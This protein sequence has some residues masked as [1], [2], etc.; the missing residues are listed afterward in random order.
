MMVMRHAWVVAVILA[1]ASVLSGQAPGVLRV[2]IVL[3]DA[4]QTPTPVPRHAL[5]ISDT[6]PTAAPR[7]ILTGAN[8]TA[9]VKLR[10]GSYTVESDRAVVFLGTAYQWTQMVEVVAGRD[11]TLALTADNAEAVPLTESSS[12]TAD[13]VPENDPSFLLAK[14]QDSVV[15]V[16][17]PTSRASGF[18]IDSRGLIATTRNAIGDATSVAVQLSPEMKVPARVLFSDDARDVAVVWINP[19]VVGTRAP[20]PLACTS[21]AAPRL[22]VGKDVLAIAAPLWRP[23]DEAWGAVTALWP[24]AIE[25]DM[26][27]GFGGAGGPV[28]TE[29]GAVVGL[30]SMGADLEARRSSD[31]SV[32]RVE[33]I[34]G[35]LSAAQAKMAAA[36]PPEATRLPVEPAQPFPAA[37]DEATQ[38][39]GTATAR[40]VSSA[41]FDVAFTTPRMVLRAQQRSDWTGG[42]SA[43]SKEAEA[44]LGRLT[45]FGAWSEYVAGV[46]HVLIVRVTPKLTEGFWKMLARG[47]ASTQGVVLPPIKRFKPGF[48]RLRASCGDTDVTPIHPFVIEQRV[49]DT[50]AIREGL[51]VFDAGAFGPHCGSVTL[52]LF[53]EAAPEKGQT[54]TLDSKL[55]NGI[56][57]DVASQRHEDH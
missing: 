53:S 43:R 21:P 25:T 52:V 37:P 34:C 15:A 57:Q 23:V 14:W 51:Y 16:W 39:T 7:R 4:A 35:G 27:L 38:S 26:R 29:E 30:T 41:D 20:L 46:P 54:I 33:A 36:D 6:P 56:W 32:V 17:S 24:R 3:P 18:V 55:I 40:V 47:A 19:S 22:V 42:S 13:A 1:S 45:D 5:L 31:V 12:A 50:D 28:F 10:P 8:G 9:E 48:L 44:R 49:S 2:T 11:A